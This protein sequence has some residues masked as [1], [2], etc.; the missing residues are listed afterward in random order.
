MQTRAPLQR[1]RWTLRLQTTELVVG[2]ARPPSSFSQTLPSPLQIAVFCRVVDNFGDIGV[3][4]RLARQLVTEHGAQVRLWL[5]RLDTLA[6]IAVGVD[7]TAEA[8]V[9]EGIDLHQWTSGSFEAPAFGMGASDAPPC[10]DHAEDLALWAHVIVEGFG[11]GL[12]EPLV[13][14]LGDQAQ[15]PRWIVL[16]YLSAEPWVD[17]HH[18][19]ASPHP[20]LGTPRHFFFPGFNGATGGL[21]R[22]RDLLARRNAFGDKERHDYWRRHGLD[23]DLT[24]AFIV[25]VLAYPDA[26]L[27]ALIDQ[28]L[29]PGGLPADC[30]GVVTGMA[31]GG[32]ADRMAVQRAGQTAEGMRVEVGAS[33]SEL[34]RA[35]EPGFAPVLLPFVVQPL[36]DQMLWA[37][38]LNIVRGEDSFVRAQWAARP[39]IWHI[40]PQADAAHLVKLE[41][42]LDGY[43]QGMDAPVAVAVRGL[44]RQFNQR[45][46]GDL[47]AWQS[48]LPHWEAWRAHARQWAAQLAEQ[49]DLASRLVAFCRE[50]L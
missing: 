39:F 18:G 32:L 41:A 22:E 37:S 26:P 36:F 7:I 17:T 2:S 28:W 8:P 35:A 47:A 42:F 19:L 15:A 10:V 20:R 6:P 27:G 40:Y 24:Q 5:D 46:E 33:R 43:C 13:A 12:P 1:H 14:C 31:P 45:P 9:I 29:K 3:C 4:W 50:Q 38:D 48:V 34:G 49:T 30:H 23:G 11:C 21:L 44:W 25:S 16:E